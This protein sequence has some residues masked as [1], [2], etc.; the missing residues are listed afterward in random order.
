[1]K[2]SRL[3]ITLFAAALLIAAGCGNWNKSS[4][5]ET[6]ATV[7]TDNTTET[8]I[9]DSTAN[10]DLRPDTLR[11]DSIVKMLWDNGYEV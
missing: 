10:L 8:T 9:A 7:T 5:D 4:N 11:G 6:E 3:R 2:I 1:M